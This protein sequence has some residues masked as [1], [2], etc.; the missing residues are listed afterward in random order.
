VGHKCVSAETEKI[1]SKNK[2]GK[3]NEIFR[4]EGSGHRSDRGACSHKNPQAKE[5][6]KGVINQD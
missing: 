1:V 4:G 5:A 2:T 6:E 3:D